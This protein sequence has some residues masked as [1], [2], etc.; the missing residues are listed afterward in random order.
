MRLLPRKA[1][2]IIIQARQGE[3]PT[4]PPTDVS[5]YVSIQGVFGCW[6]NPIPPKMGPD[7]YAVCIGLIIQKSLSPGN[8]FVIF[9]DL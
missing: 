4:K 8:G 9:N 1:H 6:K 5:G 2:C 3:E 7:G